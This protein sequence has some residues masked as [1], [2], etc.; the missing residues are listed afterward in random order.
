MKILCGLCSAQRKVWKK[1]LIMEKF[2]REEVTRSLLFNVLMLQNAVLYNI[3]CPDC[4]NIVWHQ[5]K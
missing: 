5:F 1:N 2:C 4:Q 3:L